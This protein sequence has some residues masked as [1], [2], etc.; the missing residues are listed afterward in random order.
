MKSIDVACA[1]IIRHKKILATRRSKQKARPE[2][3]EFPGGKVEKDETP[4]QCIK[5]EIEEE[6]DVKIKVTGWLQ[7]VTH[8]YPDIT[9]RLLPCYAELTSGKI[10]LKEH[11]GMKWITENELQNLDW[12]DADTNVVKQ[13]LTSGLP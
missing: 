5:R 4:E 7:P 10:K 8:T 1:V 11:S 9:I 13:I 6:L 2:K 3:W 12:S